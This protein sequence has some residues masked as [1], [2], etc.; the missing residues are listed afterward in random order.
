MALLALA[1]AGIYLY[2]LISFLDS[3]PN[4][5]DQLVYRNYPLKNCS[6]AQLGIANHEISVSR[7]LFVSFS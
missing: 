2:K 3:S 7:F 1:T 4:S 6:V 5:V